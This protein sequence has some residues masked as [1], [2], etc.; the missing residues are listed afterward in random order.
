LYVLSLY[1][2]ITYGHFMLDDIKARK[3]R[4]DLYWT[5]KPVNDALRDL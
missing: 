1:T 2:G 4:L 5:P 3:A